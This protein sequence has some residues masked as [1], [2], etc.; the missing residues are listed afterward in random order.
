[1]GQ[2]SD[3]HLLSPLI[4]NTLL[5]IIATRV[6]QEKRDD[7]AQIGKKGIKVFLTNTMIKYT[8][9]P[10]EAHTQ[11]LVEHLHNSNENLKN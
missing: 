4:F 8:E 10:Q 6:K 1:M 11:K 7:C 2:G 5:Y 9:N 3:L